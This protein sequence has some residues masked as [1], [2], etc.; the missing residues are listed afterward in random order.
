MGNKPIPSESELRVHDISN[1][2]IIESEKIVD[3]CSK[4]N[5]C[6]V[7]KVNDF[8]LVTFSNRKLI[9]ETY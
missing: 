4:G 3:D 9:I 2:K 5:K 6:T 7:T 1:N 8:F